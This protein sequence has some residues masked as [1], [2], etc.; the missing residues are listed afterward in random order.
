[1]K[2]LIGKKIGMTHIFDG[3]GNIVGVTVLQLGPCQVTRTKAKADGKNGYNAIQLSWLNVPEKKLTKPVLG[4]YKALK[5]APM[6]HLKELRVDQPESYAVGSMVTV[7]MFKPGEYVDVVGVSK[8][9]GFTGT[10]KRHNFGGGPKS[11]GSMTHRQPASGGSTDAAR[12]IR[13]KKSPGRMGGKRFTSIGLKIIEVNTAQ[14]LLLVRGSVPG[15]NGSFI[16][17]KQSSKVKK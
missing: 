5:L 4:Q 8:G 16:T 9:K 13:G 3:D 6:K 12:V 11:H 15:A 1:M 2:G 17:V 7:D 14:N 10:M